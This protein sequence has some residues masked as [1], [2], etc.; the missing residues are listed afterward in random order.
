MAGGK[1]VGVRHR[2]FSGSIPP[3]AWYKGALSDGPFQLRLAAA[4]S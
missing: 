1:D 2:I 4:P 3:G